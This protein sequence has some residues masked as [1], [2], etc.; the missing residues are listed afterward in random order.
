MMLNS[1]NEKEPESWDDDPVGGASSHDSNRDVER[2]RGGGNDDNDIR[3]QTNADQNT[4]EQSESSNKNIGCSAHMISSNKKSSI[5]AINKKHGSKL[6]DDDTEQ[7]SQEDIE[8][9]I[10]K[11]MLGEGGACF[12]LCHT[13]AIP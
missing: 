12:C 7:N 10:Q 8:E 1:K 11:I 4:V 3:L 13:K 9:M 6:S 5:R 2:G